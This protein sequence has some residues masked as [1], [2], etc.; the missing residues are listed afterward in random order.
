[1]NYAAGRAWGSV[2][3]WQC[4]KKYFNEWIFNYTHYHYS[5]KITE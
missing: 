3:V 1:M 2:A 4:V 5:L